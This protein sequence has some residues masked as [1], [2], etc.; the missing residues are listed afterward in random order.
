M[1]SIYEGWLSMYSLM[2]NNGSND[3]QQ[4]WHW[5]KNEQVQKL[6]QNFVSATQERNY[7]PS[8]PKKIIKK[9]PI[10]LPTAKEVGK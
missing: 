9:N 5:N 6:I 10:I 4:W 2:H 8:P 1:G 7:P 3:I